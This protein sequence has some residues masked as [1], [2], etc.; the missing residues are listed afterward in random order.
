MC[1]I[2]CL[3]SIYGRKSTTTAMDY[4]NI[5]FQFWFISASCLYRNIILSLVITF[6]SL[7]FILYSVSGVLFLLWKLYWMR[8][9]SL[10]FCQTKV[11]SQPYNRDLTVCKTWLLILAN[12]KIV[13]LLLIWRTDPPS[14]QWTLKIS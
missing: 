10:Q 3:A 5:L 7:W 6:I 11:V 1:I 8:I 13:F 2:L 12:N 4:G 14:F 9:V